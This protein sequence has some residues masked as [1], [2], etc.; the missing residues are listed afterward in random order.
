M[1]KSMLFLL[2]TALLAACAPMQTTQEIILPNG[3][4]GIVID[5]TMQGWPACFKAAGD[6]CRQG[7]VVYERTQDEEVRSE[8]PLTELEDEQTLAR[9][10]AIPVPPAPAVMPN[11]ERYM[12]IACK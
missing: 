10:R 4:T 5:C 6:R 7:Y 9:A 8:I 11:K 3:K 2:T 1:S 12:V